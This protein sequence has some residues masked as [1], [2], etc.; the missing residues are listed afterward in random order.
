MCGSPDTEPDEV[1]TPFC[2]ICDY[3]PCMCG[4]KKYQ[5]DKEHRE[6]QAQD[7]AYW[8]DKNPNCP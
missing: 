1:V 3:N 6:E 4:S 2:R 8:D 7:D 5:S